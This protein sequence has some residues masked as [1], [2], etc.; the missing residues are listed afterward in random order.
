[1]DGKPSQRPIISALPRE[2]VHSVTFNPSSY[3]NTRAPFARKKSNQSGSNQRPAHASFDRRP[4]VAPISPERAIAIAASPFTALGLSTPLVRALLDEQY[5]EPS[6]VQAQ[7]IPPALAGRD[8]LACA[9]TGTGKTAGFVLP[10]LQQMSTSSVRGIRAL[11]LTPT[12]ELAAQVAERVAAY[13]KYLQIRHTVIYGGV[14]QYRQEQAL[15]ASPDLLVA[16]PGRLLDLIQQRLLS[17]AGVT[18][19]V[20]DEADRMLDMGFVHDMRRIQAMLPAARQTLFFSATMA[21]AVEALARGM[22]SNPERVAIA[23][24]MTTAENITQSVMFVARADKRALLERVLR[25]ESIT[26]ALVFTRTKHGANRL[27]EQLDRSGIG[28]EAIHGNKAQNARERAL[29]AFR[30][31]HKRV[32]VATDVAARGIDVE[33]I[34]LVVNFDLPNV[35]ESYVHRIGRTGRAGASG[36][37][38][39]FCDRDE[40]PLLQDIERLIRQRLP[41]DGGGDDRPPMDA[42]A[43]EVAGSS[44]SSPRPQGRRRFRGPRFR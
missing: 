2:S 25:D 35:A 12:R 3:Q 31:G 6:P 9:Q 34:S 19:F 32:L 1:M 36:R 5:T 33:G 40:R 23:P 26:R 16:T 17:L 4:P 39:S 14:S 42:K 43:P 21:P 38:I 13:G 24:K 10:V 27:S 20:L 37:A 11:I 30:R 28:S 29:D 44:A 18:H 8:V 7:V 15:R 41:V 22:L